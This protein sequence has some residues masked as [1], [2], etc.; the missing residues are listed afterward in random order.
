MSNPLFERA[1]FSSFFPDTGSN[2]L[3]MNGGRRRQQILRAIERGWIGGGGGKRTIKPQLK[4]PLFAQI[5]PLAYLGVLPAA[6]QDGG[7]GHL[8]TKLSDGFRKTTAD[9][10]CRKL[11][12]E[13]LHSSLVRQLRQNSEN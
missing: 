10:R 1:L 3:V 11:G 13:R 6:E 7:G 2:Y 12:R 9:Y 4:P 5:D 8:G